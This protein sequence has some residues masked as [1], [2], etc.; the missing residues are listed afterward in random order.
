MK[1]S[2]QHRFLFFL[3]LL[4]L[5]FNTQPNKGQSKESLSSIHGIVREAG[6][7]EALAGVHV[8]LQNNPFQGTITGKDGVFS[9]QIKKE[10]LID[11][12]LIISYIG[13]REKKIVVKNAL[14]GDTLE[15]SLEVRAKMMEEAVIRAERIIAEEFTIQEIKQLDVY[16]NPMAKA[17]PLLAVNA[18][19]SSTTI[20]ENANIS[21]RGSRPA[22]T[23]IFLNQV[24]VYDAVRFARLN[25][26]GTM[27]IFNTS[28]MERMQVFPGNPPLEFG[29]AT[30]G[31][32][33]IQT[34]N[35]P[36]QQ[37]AYTLSASLANLG[38]KI[39]Q[40]AGDQTGIAAFANYQP[41]EGLIG[42]NQDAFHNLDHFNSGDLGIHVTNKINTNSYFKVFNYSNTEAYAYN[43]AMPSYQGT[44]NHQ[45]KR[46]FSI[47]NYV[48]HHKNGKINING[49]ANFSDQQF[50]HGN[51]NLS[52]YKQD[53]YLAVN[54]Q[55]FIN[56]LSIKS[57][58]SFNHRI[59]HF[60]GSVPVYQYAL[61][62]EHPSVAFDKKIQL[63]LPEAFVYFKYKIT[64]NW[65][66]GLGLRQKFPTKQL[67]EYTSYQGNLTYKPGDHSFT[68]AAGKYNKYKMPDA[69]NR[70]IKLYQSQQLSLDYTFDQPHLKLNAALFTKTIQSDKTK[71]AI[72]G[73]EA[74]IKTNLF[75]EHLQSQLAYTY[76]HGQQQTGQISY[77]YKYD[78]DYY[79]RA[80]LKYQFAQ[81]TDISLI[82]LHREGNYYQP[83]Q[84]SNYH[85]RLD[86]YQPVYTPRDEKKRLP[87]YN[88]IDLSISKLW[89]VSNSFT[90]I[91]FLNVSNLLNKKNPRSMSYN[92]DYSD[93]FYEYFSFRTAYFGVEIN[94][95]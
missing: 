34:G 11:N 61:A 5:V 75:T 46:N 87:D 47:A 70:Q 45:K 27:S 41:S 35:N 38:G 36:P 83:V 3:F 53:Y 19:P 30:S 10:K 28:I 40:K 95:M 44:L 91:T 89:P 26:M 9:L 4:G 58:I 65:I 7:K 17:D 51:T 8:F 2:H 85:E 6:S 24:P 32:V 55:R 74:Y 48:N 81:S 86:V 73:A 68:L 13:Y 14:P 80:S 31:L 20:E 79:I 18:M 12:T 64:D 84:T 39:E 15:I 57:G 93:S 1:Q 78:M 71:T 77:P 25:G 43:L 62:P 21:L 52:I 69:E 63:L 90:L 88:K 92:H 59:H 94:F 54:Y 67:K 33:S 37:P 60:T 29:S 42:I 22:E 16:L 66:S 50:D 76:I 82:M 72:K 49:K 56:Q 23:G